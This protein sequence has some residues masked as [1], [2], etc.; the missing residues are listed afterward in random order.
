MAASPDSAP[1][2]SP[3]TADR[4]LDAFSALLIEGGEKA[5]TLD[6]VA[7]RAGVSKGGLLY[8]YGSKDALAHGLVERLARFV[9][10]DIEA[11][12]SAPEGPVAFF[13]RTSTDV[14][15]DFD[16]AINATI[17]LAHGGSSAAV[18]AI[19][20]ARTRWH[21]ALLPE[22]RDSDVAWALLFM[23]DGLYL[24]SANPQAYPDIDRGPTAEF[25]ERMVA[26]AR[27]LT[28]G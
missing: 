15:T 12:T 2:A 17:A 24:A 26:V 13:I 25:A 6:A 5:A 4:L 20:H 14:G 1:T 22:T 9:D 28:A 8:H 19:A 3:S 10:A 27:R 18:A 11:M 7:A 23:S 21:E 16:V